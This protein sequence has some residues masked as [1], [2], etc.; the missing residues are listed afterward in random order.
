MH[1]TLRRDYSRLVELIKTDDL[2]TPLYVFNDFE[3]DFDEDTS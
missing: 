3:E 2:S 1:L